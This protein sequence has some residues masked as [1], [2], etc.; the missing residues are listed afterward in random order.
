MRKSKKRIHGNDRAVMMLC[1]DARRRWMQ[2]GENRKGLPDMCAKCGWRQGEQRDHII[3]LGP[4]PRVPHGIGEY[5]EKMLYTR[6]QNLCKNC[7]RRKTNEERKKRS[8]DS[9]I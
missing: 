2:Y 3:P 9:S 4:R 7:H 8:Q 5:F 1:R 6:C